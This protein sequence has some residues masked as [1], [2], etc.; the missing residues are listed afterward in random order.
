MGE[1]GSNHPGACSA[2]VGDGWLV[3]VGERS[4]GVALGMYC[5][6]AASLRPARAG[7]KVVAGDGSE[8]VVVCQAGVSPVIGERQRA[9]A[10]RTRA[11]VGEPALPVWAQRA[12]VHRR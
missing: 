5:E 4:A 7:S 6:T 12:R 1:A 9:A 11:G 3:R 8:V 10:A 2:V